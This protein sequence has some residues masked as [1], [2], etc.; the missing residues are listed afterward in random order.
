VNT[1]VH[2]GRP[3][4]R[5]RHYHAPDYESG[6]ETGFVPRFAAKYYF[7]PTAML[8]ANVGKGFR[9]GG[10]SALQISTDAC[11]NAVALA[12]IAQS[13]LVQIRQP[14]QLRA[15]TQNGFCRM[16]EQSSTCRVLH[17]L[18]GPAGQPESECL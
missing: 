7:A 18:E 17:R 11:R 15:G 4:W 14:D 3:D 12:G 16:A 2:T 13:N 9:A 5:G 1:S 6:S 8:Y 10:P